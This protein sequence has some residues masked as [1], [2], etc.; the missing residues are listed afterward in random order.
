MELTSITN[1]AARPMF[2]AVSFL[3]ETPRNG[4]MP[5]NRASTKLLTTAGV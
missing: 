3:A 5:R 2:Q 4:Q 1:M